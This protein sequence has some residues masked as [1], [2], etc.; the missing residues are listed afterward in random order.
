[1]KRILYCSI[2]EHYKRSKNLGVVKKIDTQ[3][4]CFEKADCKVF[5]RSPIGR[6]ITLP[7]SIWLSRRKWNEISLP[8]N[9]DALYI[10]FDG[11]DN[12][13]VKLLKKYKREN[14]NGKALLEIATYP[15]KAEYVKGL[16]YLYYLQSVI[17]IHRAKKYLD[18]VVLIS[19]GHSSFMNVPVINIRNSVDYETT[20]VRMPAGN[21]SAIHII[22]VASFAAWHGYDRLIEGLHNY[23]RL[24]KHENVVLHMVGRINNVR[25][26]GLLQMVQKYDLQKNVIFHDTLTGE[27]LDE[28]YNICDL[29]CCA[30][31]AHRKGLYVS[32]ELKSHEYAAKGIPMLTASCLDIYHEDTARY[33]CRFPANESPVDF[34][35]IVRFYHTIYDGQDKQLIA[36]LIRDTFRKYCSADEN[37]KEVVTF[38]N[39][40]NK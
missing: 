20:T 37:F 26:L 6:N 11:A 17:A 31:G 21:G 34:K 13:M 4:K 29:A 30:I 2:R 12:S 8:K 14:P 5:L 35:E 25:E 27:K 22:C 16:G 39:N 24:P 23:F 15:F 33:I 36:D 1:M 19:S 40:R 18:R 28:V 3:K 10:R 9:I 32:S 7:G 38:V